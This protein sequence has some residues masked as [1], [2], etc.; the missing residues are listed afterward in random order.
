MIRTD[1]LALVEGLPNNQATQTVIY[2]L[3]EKSCDT[4]GSILI[5]SKRWF[6]FM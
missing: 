5:G 1:D 4:D 6:V 3:H 2:D